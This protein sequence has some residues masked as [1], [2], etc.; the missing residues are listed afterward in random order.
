MYPPASDMRK[1]RTQK[2]TDGGLFYVIQNGIRLTG[3]S[4]WATGAKHDEQDFVET[5]AIHPALAE[6]Y[7]RGVRASDR[8]VFGVPRASRRKR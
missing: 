2:K 1:D 3:M 8:D 4:A 6:A 7:C 5:C